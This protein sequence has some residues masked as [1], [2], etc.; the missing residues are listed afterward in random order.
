MLNTAV[1]EGNFPHQLLTSSGK[2]HGDLNLLPYKIRPHQLLKFMVT[3]KKRSSAVKAGKSMQY[4]AKP[5]C[6]RDLMSLDSRVRPGG[7]KLYC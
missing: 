4:Q 6:T 2:V 5:L 1:T 7:S 3:G